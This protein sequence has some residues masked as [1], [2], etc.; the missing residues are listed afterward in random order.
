MTDLAIREESP[1]AP[2]IKTDVVSETTSAAAAARE[3]AAI[4]ARYVVAMRRPRDWRDVRLKLLEACKR[5]GFAATAMYAKPIGG[6]Q[7]TGFSIRFVE[8][9]LRSIQNVDVSA[10]LVAEDGKVRVFRVGVTDLEANLT[11]SDDVTVERTVERRDKKDRVVLGE[12]TNSRSE[13][14]YIVLATEDELLVKTNNQKSKAIRNCGV[15][16]LPGD[17]AEEAKAQ[18]L[19]TVRD[20]DARD[21][22]AATKALCDAA[23]TFGIAPAEIEAYLGNPLSQMTSAQRQLMRQILTALREGETT[24]AEII[25]TQK[26]EQA[27]TKGMAGLKEKIAKKPDDE[28]ARRAEEVEMLRR[29]KEAEAGR[30]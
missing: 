17:I 19:A 7:V 9:A 20:E 21:P 30:G 27:P 6:K 1:V 8:E 28:A 2:A 23:Y 14:V 18:I 22:E 24:W 16:I 29:E 13:K 3:K 12:R 4:E 15:R 25:G 26:G 10:P 5:P 11:Y